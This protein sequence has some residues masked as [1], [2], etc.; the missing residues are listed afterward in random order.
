MNKISIMLTESQLME[1]IDYQNEIFFDKKLGLEREKLNEIEVYDN[2]VI[3]ITGVRRAG[4]STMML[5]LMNKNLQNSLFLNFEDPRLAGFEMTDFQRLD[6]IIKERNVK[7]LFFDEIQIFEGWELYV[8]QKL[9]EGYKVVVTGSNASLMSRELGTKLTGRN[10]PYELLPFSFS[11]FLKFKELESNSSATEKYLADGG[12][13]EF[14]ITG[15]GLVLQRLLIDVLNRDIAVR[16]GIRDVNSL[17]QLAV[18]LI[19]NIGKPVSATKMKDLFGLKSVSAITDYFS[20]LENSY[21]V[22]FLPKFSY[23]VKT[24][25]RNPRKVYVIDL[26]LFTHNSIVFTEEKGR[27]LENAV[28][29]HLRR[30]YQEIYYFNEKKECDFVAIQKGKAAE[31]VQSCYEITADNMK[32]EFDGL[33]D[34]L[35]FFDEP[36]GKIVTFDQKDSFDVDGKTIE[37]VPLHEYLLQ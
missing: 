26:G 8:R 6:S 29:L 36:K 18:Y 16:Y 17:F 12:F 31:V 2:F 13:P 24:Q 11:E 25:I 3:L 34:A 33:L 28:Y 14:L 27:R 1:V 19:S 20:H 22:Q 23:S 15:N 10:L 30:K 35:N 9:D 4:K 37:L 32:R 5:Q 7:Q 21:I